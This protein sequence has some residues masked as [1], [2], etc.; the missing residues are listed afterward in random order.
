MDCGDAMKG[1]ELVDGLIEEG[2]VTSRKH[3]RIITRLL[4]LL[5]AWLDAHGGG[6]LLS[7]DNRVR[8]SGRRVRKPDI[9]LVRAADHPV[10]D[11]ETLVSP[12]DLVIEVVT[13][14]RCDEDRDRVAKVADYEAIGARTYWIIDP[15]TDTLDVFLLDAN[16]LYGEPR[17]YGP[18]ELVDGAG[19]GFE[20]LC[21]RVAGL[22]H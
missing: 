15:E 9:L 17:R 5:L 16:G 7:Q 1:A 4:S 20:G 6:E 12:P 22:D 19:L 11:E 18:T 13:N 14:T 3:G 8:I 10:F 2:E 21:F